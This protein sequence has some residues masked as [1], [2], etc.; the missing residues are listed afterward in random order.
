MCF[1]FA[2]PTRFCFVLLS[3]SQHPSCFLLQVLLFIDWWDSCFSYLVTPKSISSNP[4]ARPR[5]SKR[6]NAASTCEIKPEQN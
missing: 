4:S 1:I 3:V 2:S 6:L 5:H